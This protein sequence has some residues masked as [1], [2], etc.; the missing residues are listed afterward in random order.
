MVHQSSLVGWTCGI[1]A[2]QQQK[3]MRQNRSSSTALTAA[4]RQ[5]RPCRQQ[6]RR[7]P[8]GSRKRRRRPSRPQRWTPSCRCCH[9]CSSSRT[10]LAAPS[11][12]KPA[13]C[14]FVKYGEM[15]QLRRFTHLNMAF[16][17][18]LKLCFIFP[19]ANCGVITPKGSFSRLP[20]VA[21]DAAAFARKLTVPHSRVPC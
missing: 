17:K 3:L 8:T 20:V 1:E 13:G 11:L 18:P 12:I 6:T 21:P 7:Q 10:C 16:A 15:W 2:T 5:Q 14:R 9:L 19:H 4:A